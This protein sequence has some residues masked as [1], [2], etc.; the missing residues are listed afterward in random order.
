MEMDIYTAFWISPFPND[1]YVNY[2]FYPGTVFGIEFII[3]NSSTF[4]ERKVTNQPWP[5]A[6]ALS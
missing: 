6:Y 5:V 3:S 1:L 4:E 2:N